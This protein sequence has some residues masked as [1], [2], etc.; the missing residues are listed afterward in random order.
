[1]LQSPSAPIM[2]SDHNLSPVLVKLAARGE[3]RK[4]EKWQN[5]LCALQRGTHQQTGR[6]YNLWPLFLPDIQ[7]SEYLMITWVGAGCI[8][9]SHSMLSLGIQNDTSGFFLFSVLENGVG[10]LQILYHCE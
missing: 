9:A 10:L 3:Y 6:G 4:D 2:V 1:M 5:S 8:S 7:R